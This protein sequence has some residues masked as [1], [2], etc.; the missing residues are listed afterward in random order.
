MLRAGF[1]QLIAGIL[2]AGC[3]ATTPEAPVIGTADGTESHVSTPIGGTP[4]ASAG[5]LVY[6]PQGGMPAQAGT[7]GQLVRVAILVPQ[8]GSNAAIGQALLQAAQLAVFDLNEPQF[9]LIPKDTHGTAEGARA[10][11]DE[12]AREGV[13][14]I[15]GPLFA[16]EVEAAK[17]AARNYG[18]TVIGF[19]TDWRQAGGNVYTMGVLP[20]GQAERIADYAARQGLRRIAV[21]APKDLYGDAVLTAFENT[22]RR[23]GLTVIKTVRIASNGSDVLNAVQQL[24]G[25]QVVQGMPPYDALF[26]PV[27][28]GALQ[29]LAGTLKAYGLGSDR[30]RYLGTGL[31][32]DQ[33]VW[34]DA[35]MA[36]ALYAAP[37]PQIRAAFERNYQRIYGQTPPRLASIGYDAAAL[38]IVLSRN[39]AAGRGATFDRVGLTNPNGFS[40]VDGI[41]RFRPDGLAERGMAILQIGA[42]SAHLIEAAPASFLDMPR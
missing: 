23:Y 20:F 38:A 4:M 17:N 30:V 13:K 32:D 16:Q 18:L 11:V 12:A 35:N 42:G 1:F 22:A 40:G 28:G 25:G 2:L 24:T 37:S 14:L 34:R 6:V 26:M 39:A 27:G 36:G 10:A 29:T 31:W 33:S 5:G 41:F 3:V 8:S 9:E 7:P 15:L 19:S 21:V